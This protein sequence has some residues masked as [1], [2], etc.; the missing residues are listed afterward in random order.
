MK[1]RK[2]FFLSLPFS[3]LGLKKIISHHHHGCGGEHHHFHRY[4]HPHGH[5]M[6]F[7]SWRLGL[8]PEQ[9]SKLEELYGKM[10]TEGKPLSEK[11]E[12]IRKTLT[13]EFRKEQF[14]ADRLEKQLTPEMHDAAHE[15]FL[16][17]IREFHG[18]LTPVQRD[19]VAA[20]FERRCSR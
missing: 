13:E 4:G 9:K 8:S 2:L 16:N 1:Y 11:H 12:E 10:K 15:L 7:I 3:L 17:G 19:K 14:A 6:K 5:M 18:I 20:H